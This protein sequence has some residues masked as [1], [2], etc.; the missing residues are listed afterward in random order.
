MIKGK[1]IPAGF[2]SRLATAAAFCVLAGTAAAEAPKFSGFLGD[3]SQ[4]ESRSDPDLV[5][6]Y[7]YVRPGTDWKAYGGVMVETVKVYLKPGAQSPG[8]DPHDLEALSEHFEHSLLRELGGDYAVVQEPKPGAM[9]LRIAITE[10]VPVQTR[11]SKGVDYLPILLIGRALKGRSISVNV[12]SV[13]IEAE[14][15]D[16]SSGER[17]AAVVSSKIAAGADADGKRPS[18]WQEAQES[19]DFWAHRLRLFLDDA[20]AP[21]GGR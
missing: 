19:M 15:I 20:R 12:G 16:E 7:R 5:Y 1:I 6:N 21:S 10:V 13:A 9:R 4:L 2:A 3:Y 18:T 8:F 14:L 11:Q 17:L